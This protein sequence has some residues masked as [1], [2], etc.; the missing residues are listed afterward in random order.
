MGAAK[1]EKRSMEREME[2]VSLEKLRRYRENLELNLVMVVDNPFSTCTLKENE[3]HHQVAFREKWMQQLI[4][5]QL[6]ISG[7]PDKIK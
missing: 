1:R 3:S 4:F 5:T 7:C 2:E 6:L